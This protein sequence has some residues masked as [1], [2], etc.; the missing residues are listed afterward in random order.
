MGEKSVQ[1]KMP[2]RSQAK[3][4]FEEVHEVALTKEEETWMTTIIA[5]L[6][7]GILPAGRNEY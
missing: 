1:G 5:C 7:S 4:R 2:V 6:S 3:P